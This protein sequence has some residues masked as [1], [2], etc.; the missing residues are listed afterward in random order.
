MI[1]A[2][3]LLGVLLSLA[4]VAALLPATHAAA[5]A[6]VW[7]AAKAS[8]AVAISVGGAQ[9]VALTD[10]TALEPGDVIRT[11][12]NG[13]V[14]LTRGVETILISAN[15]IVGI[16]RN[17]DEGLTTIVAQAG[18]IRLESEKR[19]GRH[20]EVD[21]PSLAA[22]VNGGQFRLGV[23]GDD[24]R[25]DVVS[26]EVEVT[27]DRSG[28]HALVRPDQSATASAQGASGLSLSGAGMFSRIEPGAPH[29]APTMPL[30]WPG[31]STAFRTAADADRATPPQAGTALPQVGSGPSI[32]AGGAREV[33]SGWTGRVTDYISSLLGSDH[34]G[35]NG[36]LA[37]SDFAIPLAIG[38]VVM[39]GVAVG[40]LRQR[41]KK[42]QGVR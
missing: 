34:R 18:S 13:R 1:A 31:L 39:I 30:Q 17:Q 22:A 42:T 29:R 28:Q 25:V 36:V 4:V 7:R 8:G 16:A 23:S 32:W 37:I 21:T 10:G 12:S 2:K 5:Q 41:G 11:G 3:R 26:G 40:R 6:P 15:A 19:D 14:L 38:L 24:S 35:S 20:I 27:D 33:G 9:A